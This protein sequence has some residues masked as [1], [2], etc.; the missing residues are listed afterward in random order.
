MLL[1]QHGV[2]TGLDKQFVDKLGAALNK[3]NRLT[4][5]LAEM[6]ERAIEAESVLEEIM[7]MDAADV[8]RAVR[9][10]AS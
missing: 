8:V 2:S 10:N 3:V 6:E 1:T 4:R 7:E 9:G 5:Q